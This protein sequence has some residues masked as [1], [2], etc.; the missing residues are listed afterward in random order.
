MKNLLLMAFCLLTFTMNAQDPPTILSHSEGQVVDNGCD[1]QYRPLEGIYDTY[2]W[3][4]VPGA[5]LY[6]LHTYIP[7][8]LFEVIDV[9][10]PTTSYNYICNECLTY[11]PTIEI[12]V[13]ALVNGQWTEFSP[14][15]TVNFEP[16]NTDCPEGCMDPNAHNYDP[17]A[18]F[19]SEDCETCDDGIQNGDE[20]E[21]DCGGQLC[22]PCA[23]IS[24]LQCSNVNIYIDL[25]NPDHEISTF[26]KIWLINANFLGFSG[27]LVDVLTDGSDRGSRDVVS[28]GGGFHEIR[29]IGNF[30]NFDWTT[31]GAGIDGD[32]NG[33]INNVDKGKAWRSCLPI[34]FSDI[35]R[36][37]K[38]KLRTLTPNGYD[39]CTGKVRVLL[40]NEGQQ[41]IPFQTCEGNVGVVVGNSYS[42]PSVHLTDVQEEEITHNVEERS[43][44][45]SFSEPKVYPNPGTDMAKIDWVQNNAEPVQIRI[46]NMMGQPV[47]TNKYEGEKGQNTV[48]LE[49]DKFQNGMYIIHL[50]SEK[51][52][53]TVVWT[54]N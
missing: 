51:D 41:V 15:I 36:Y 16:V 45:I 34:Q 37:R 6:N 23:I 49:T 43:S 10:V 18:Q 26:E 48:I 12:K 19:D 1:G 7:G 21:V 11:F 28:S 8:A 30:I 44:E 4:E 46:F 47:S 13:R 50:E 38:Y 33:I 29:R 3:T 24:T 27:P 42:A 31:L 39:D 40:V 52:R 2:L 22:A 14:I 5:T 35:W 9:N 17:N 53:K 32:P 54:K 25:H 20:T